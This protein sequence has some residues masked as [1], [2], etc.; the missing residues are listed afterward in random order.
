[1]AH[2]TGM[3]TTHDLLAPGRA[4]EALAR[5]A[6]RGHRPSWKLLLEQ[7]PQV[8]EAESRWLYPA[9]LHRQPGGARRAL[10]MPLTGE[11]EQ[12]LD[13]IETLASRPAARNDPMVR[14]LQ[15]LL[16]LHVRSEREWLEHAIRS[17][18]HPLRQETAIARYLAQCA[19]LLERT[20]RVTAPDGRVMTAIAA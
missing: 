17:H 18:P 11:H 1:M 13:L 8:I 15:T 4:L 3:D 6:A 20:R 9:L 16:L 19:P 12:M 10:L 14:A 5:R 2:A 7:L